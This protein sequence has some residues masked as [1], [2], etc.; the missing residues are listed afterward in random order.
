VID[1]GTEQQLVMSRAT[2]VPDV[3]VGQF[4]AGAAGAYH[5]FVA[6]PAFLG[7]APAVDFEVRG[8]LRETQVVRP[9]TVELQQIAKATGGRAY[10]LANVDQLSTAIPPGLPVP[11]EPETPFKLWNHWLALAMFCGLLTLEWALRKRWRLV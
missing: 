11:L 1:G 2:D 9:E 6:A 8:S 5:A 4:V 10:T 3:F 7:A